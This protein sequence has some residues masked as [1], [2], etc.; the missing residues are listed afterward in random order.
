MI[1]GSTGQRTALR[2]NTPT[3]QDT[4]WLEAQGNV[5]PEEERDTRVCQNISDGWVYKTTYDLRMR[6]EHKGVR[7][8]IT[9]QGTWKHTA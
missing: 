5:Q 7:T 2:R 6:E 4:R 3:S 8:N 9:A 1:A